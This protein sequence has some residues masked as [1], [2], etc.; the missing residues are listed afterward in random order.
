MARGEYH[1]L[2]FLNKSFKPGEE[3][4][5]F[6]TFSIPAEWNNE[7]MK[8][9]EDLTIHVQAYGVQTFELESCYQAMI[10]AFPNE[11]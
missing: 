6:D 11:F 8:Q 3:V 5:L 9:M 10:S 7:E 4:V 1:F 2:I